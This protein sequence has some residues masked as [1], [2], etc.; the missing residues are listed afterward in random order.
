MK[1]YIY[2][3]IIA[4]LLVACTHDLPFN[5]HENP[6]KLVINAFLDAD[7]ETND[8]ILGITGREK[9]GI[10]QDASVNIYVNG[11]LKEH[12]PAPTVD[13]SEHNNK[14]PHFKTSVRFGANDVVRV[15]AQTNDKK[16]QAWA[17]AK[18]PKPTAIENVDTTTFRKRTEWSS[19]SRKYM[20]FK[21]TFTDNQQ[22]RNFYRIT[23]NYQVAFHTKSSDTAKD[24][25]IYETYT[26]KLITNE[27]VVLTD[28]TPMAEDDDNF[29]TAIENKFG[30]FDNSRTNGTYTMTT[31]M[32]MP[33]DQFSLASLAPSNDI[34][35]KKL[36]A[37]IQ[38]R[39]LRI[40]EASYYYLKALNTYISDDFEEYLNLP[41]KFPSNVEGGTGIVGVEIGSEHL[42]HIGDYTP[43]LGDYSPV[44]TPEE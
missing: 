17:E 12:I 10:V 36:S 6:P 15:E 34:Y 33:F 30:V 38:V 26:S 37:N 9:A 31:S 22:G 1:K 40:S 13:T 18:V 7:K 29:F 24:T 21:T 20:K 35:L 4:L 39:L 41:V 3:T 27:D 19:Y 42:I 14:P 44:D 32:Y 8:I 11:T 5:I 25:V 23:I 2:S 28:G 16:Y 43:T